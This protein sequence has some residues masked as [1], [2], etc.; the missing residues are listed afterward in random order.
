MTSASKI[1][2]QLED[3]KNSKLLAQ[4]ILQAMEFLKRAN[5][6]L[7]LPSKKLF[8]SKLS[9]SNSEVFTPPLPKELLVEF[10]VCNKHLVASAYFLRN[11]MDNKDYIMPNLGHN[12]STGDVVFVSFSHSCISTHR[13]QKTNKKRIFRVM[14][15]GDRVGDLF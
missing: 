5:D 15:G 3:I 11:T 9:V 14:V 8:P 6:E 1:V 10:S 12:I 13:F 2:D 4:N 7:I